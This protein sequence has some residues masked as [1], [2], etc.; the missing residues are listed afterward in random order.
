M[1]AIVRKNGQLIAKSRGSNQQI[2]ISQD[3]ARSSQPSTM[4]AEDLADLCV[5]PQHGHSEKKITEGLRI[6]R[7]IGGIVHT[8]IQFREGD[9]RHGAPLIGQGL[10]LAHDGAVAVQVMDDSISVDE[11]TEAHRVGTGRVNTT[12]SA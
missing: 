9:D 8:L 1:S 3:F 5:D 11:I 6:I 7:W 4:L 12:R 2:K 10:Q